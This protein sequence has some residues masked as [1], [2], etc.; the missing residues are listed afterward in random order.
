MIVTRYRRLESA[1]GVVCVLAAAVAGLG[2]SSASGQYQ[3][4]DGRALDRNLQQG[5]GGANAPSRPNPYGRYSDAIITGNVG[6]LG[7]FRG[8][9]GYRAPGEFRG[10]TSSDDTYNFRRVALPQSVRTTPEGRVRP[11][12]QNPQLDPT[13]V[14]G[15]VLLRG[16][17]GARAGDLNR[18]LREF[19]SSLVIDDTSDSVGR[20]GPDRLLDVTRRD[21]F[22]G[23]PERAGLM[24]DDRGQL[25]QLTTSPLTGLR[26]RVVGQLGQPEIEP[27]DAEAREELDERERMN[28]EASR[29]GRLSGAIVGRQGDER[30]ERV[31]QR[32]GSRQLIDPIGMPRFEEVEPGEDVYADLLREID[33]QVPGGLRVGERQDAQPQAQAERELTRVEQLAEEFDRTRRGEGID[34]EDGDPLDRLAAGLSYDLPP[35]ESFVGEGDN[36]TNRALA[37]AEQLMAQERY[38]QAEALYE[39][40]LVMRPDYAIAQMGRVH[41]QVGAGLYLSAAMNLRQALVRNPQLIAARYRGAVMPSPQRLREIEDELDDL[42]RTDAEAA[43]IL[44]GYLAYQTSSEAELR[45]SLD[46]LEEQAGDDDMPGLLRRIWLRDEQAPEGQG[47]EADEGGEA[48]PDQAP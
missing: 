2:D 31:D 16:G 27:G 43:A 9:V 39:R 22:M 26:R 12:A 10:R 25:L 1:L 46:R 11:S 4:G 24:A 30:D 7:A 17:T 48:V 38:F 40:V 21:R 42:A 8:D 32:L 18:Q 5:S 34:E 6:G 14:E 45:E 37:Q 13:R 3:L 33:A 44:Q 19:P 35:V 15:T 47:G 20:V 41:A 28:L 23:G 29:R 36:A